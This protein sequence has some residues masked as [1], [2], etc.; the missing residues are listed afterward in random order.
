MSS[1]RG[2]AREEGKPKPLKKKKSGKR[3]NL[4]DSKD[5]N[6]DRRALGGTQDA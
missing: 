6:P 3:K 5:N 2:D 1:I 4:P